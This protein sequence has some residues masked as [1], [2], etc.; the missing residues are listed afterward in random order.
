L[1][2]SH[3]VIGQHY[4]PCGLIPDPRRCARTG[5]L[6]RS[7]EP[8]SCNW[9]ATRLARSCEEKHQPFAGNDPRCATLASNHPPS[10]ALRP[11]LHQERNFT[12][13][14][15]R[16]QQSS[17]PQTRRGSPSRDGRGGIQSTLQDTTTNEAEIRAE[18]VHPNLKG[19]VGV[20][21]RAPTS[22]A[23]IT[24]LWGASRPT[25]SVQSATLSTTICHARGRRRG[26]GTLPQTEGG[27]PR[28][29][30]AGGSRQYRDPSLSRVIR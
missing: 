21:S 23:C 15:R 20:W 5:R 24:S 1:L 11:L 9:V 6:P 13:G 16:R 2:K 27:G 30:L 28:D 7:G 10:L 29:E 8:H 17:P 14:R 22:S 3:P 26:S 19:A 4:R 18:C 12:G 25:A